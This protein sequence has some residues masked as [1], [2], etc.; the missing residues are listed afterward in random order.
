[1]GRMVMVAILLTALAMIPSCIAVGGTSND[2]RPTTG[3]ELIDLK[4]AL[5]RGA[6]TQAEYDKTKA[7]ILSRAGH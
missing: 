3:Q 4:T 6:I 7:D 2:R 5:D 1:M